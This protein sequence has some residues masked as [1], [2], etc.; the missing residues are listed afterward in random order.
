MFLPTNTFAT[1]RP[2]P[3]DFSQGLHKALG[4]TV[5]VLGPGKTGSRRSACSTGSLSTGSLSTGPLSTGS[6]STGESVP[7]ISS[8]YRPP[9]CRPG[10]KGPQS[11][12]QQEGVSLALVVCARQTGREALKCGRILAPKLVISRFLNTTFLAKAMRPQ[13]HISRE[14]GGLYRYSNGGGTLCISRDSLDCQCP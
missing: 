12:P 7:K 8:S 5:A 10:R 3:G 14:R 13:W 11:P 4:G 6:Y 1:V 9:R 2:R